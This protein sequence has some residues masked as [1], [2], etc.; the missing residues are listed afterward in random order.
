MRRFEVEGKVHDSGEYYCDIVF[1]D[2]KIAEIQMQLGHGLKS[3]DMVRIT[4]D[5]EIE[6]NSE[7]DGT[8]RDDIVLYGMDV[9]H[10]GG[11]R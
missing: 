9:V 7:D 6:E 11:E 4:G 2:H 3:G 10:I 5:I 1:A 8:S